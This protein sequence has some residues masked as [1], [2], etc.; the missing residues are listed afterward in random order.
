MVTDQVKQLVGERRQLIVDE[1]G[2]ILNSKINLTSKVPEGSKM[3]DEEM[4]SFDWFVE[5]RW[6]YS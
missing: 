1:E 6:D 3:T 2:R 5:G 4:L